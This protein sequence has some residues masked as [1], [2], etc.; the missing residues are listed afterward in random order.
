MVN[1]PLVLCV[2]LALTA[3]AC[4][5]PAAVKRFAGRGEETEE[6]PVFTSEEFPAPAIP[7]PPAQLLFGT[8][9]LTNELSWGLFLNRGQ[10][11]G[12]ALVLDVLPDTP[13]ST[14]GLKPGDV[15]SWIDGMAVNNHEQLLVA[16]RDG[17]VDQHDMT[18]R[19]VD[20]TTIDIEAILVPPA[21][22][23]LIDYLETRFATT[24]DPISRYL[25]AEQVDDNDR[26]IELIRGLIAEH[27]N[28][29]EGHAL[30][31]RRLLDKVEQSASG[32]STGAEF[33]SPS[34][35][36]ELVTA[37]DTAVELDPEAP[38]LYR[39]RSQMHLSL[40][41]GLSAEA[42]ASTA[43]QMDELSAEAH[44]LLGTSLLTLGNYTDAIER[45]HLAVELNRFEPKYYV[46]LALCYRA[47]GR[48]DDAQ[49]T[50]TGARS[51]VSDPAVRARLDELAAGGSP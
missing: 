18:V 40:G 19:R 15:I 4:A 48:E 6:A 27:P 47:L 49:D 31:A 35:I 36:E 5:P 11:S 28:F 51:L 3:A 10:E 45:L 30:L 24:P 20:G 22:F 17:D 42:D 8:V 34:E 7:N 50:F 21:G 26:A 2:A 39:A 43:L 41:D 9:I 37:I 14:L 23:S 25:L 32:G 1:K 33:T 13:A 46:N 38:S 29:A 16:F 44:Y 12:G